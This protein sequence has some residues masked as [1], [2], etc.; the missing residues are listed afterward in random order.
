MSS[1][2]VSDIVRGRKT[3]KVQFKTG[4]AGEKV[5]RGKKKMFNKGPSGKEIEG[6]EKA[7]HQR[8]SEGSRKRF[9]K[10]LPC[11]HPLFSVE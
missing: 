5:Y 3:P 2:I 1:T 4:E 6:G 8:S 11:R 7:H 10:D 9:W